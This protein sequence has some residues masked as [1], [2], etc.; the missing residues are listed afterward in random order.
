MQ[1]KLKILTCLIA[2]PLSL[3]TFAGL[4]N[5][6][7]AF[8]TIK[9]VSIASVPGSDL[10][11]EGLHLPNTSECTF[12]IAGQGINT[13]NS[14]PGDTVMKIGGNG[15]SDAR[16]D[17]AG[18]TIGATSGTGCVSNSN[19]L[20]GLYLIDGSPGASVK[21][22]ITDPSTGSVIFK[23]AGCAANY[24][25]GNNADECL[26]VSQV[27]AT[28]TIRLAGPNDLIT[29]A[30]STPVEGQALIALGGQAIAAAQLTPGFEYTV[31]FDITVA[32]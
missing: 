24:N 13:G 15:G 2:L 30:G 10:I 18:G 27:Q 5:L 12:L 8:K 23:A 21:V 19:A 32:Y 25:D 17:A 16:Q 4:E 3:N 20:Y 7:G 31:P 29:D 9:D 26:P 14:Y 6:E 22:T 11:M 1:L 28:Q